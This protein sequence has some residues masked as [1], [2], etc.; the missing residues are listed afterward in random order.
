MLAGDLN[1]R[2]EI[3]KNLLIIGGHDPTSGAGIVRDSLVCAEFGVHPLTVITCLTVQNNLR[4]GQAKPVSAEI[5]LQSLEILFEDFEI[6][7]VKLGM[8]CNIEIMQAFAEFIKNKNLKIITDT[9]FATSS[10]GQAFGDELMDFFKQNI[11]PKTFMLTPNLLELERLGNLNNFDGYLLIKGGH[12]DDDTAT[13]KLVLGQEEWV[14]EGL[15]LPKQARGTGC[16]LAS[17]IACGLVN[18]LPVLEAVCEGKKYISRSIKN[19]Y[20]STK[21]AKTHF[22]AC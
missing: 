21:S 15:K 19:A 3:M 11:V 9:P 6:E 18:N 14:F 5:F 2:Y 12:S 17:A 7:V 13:D 1:E 20:H 4:F 8:F 10:G 16:A 22:L